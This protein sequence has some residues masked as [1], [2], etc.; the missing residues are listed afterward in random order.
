[1]KTSWFKK[2]ITYLFLALFFTMEMASVHAWSH[3]ND[4]DHGVDCTICIQ[5]NTNN[6][7]PA[8]SPDLQYSP[9]EY[10][11]FTV[12]KDITNS[13]SFVASNTIAS[14]Q[15]FSRPPPSLL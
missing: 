15:L 5:I 9:I 8:I 14:D 3:I 13:Y 4:D 11:E 1:M 10:V 2:S 6:L 7:T 12:K